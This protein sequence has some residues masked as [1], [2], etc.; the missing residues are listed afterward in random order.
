MELFIQ[1][2]RI[3][4]TIP[5]V[6]YSE[7]SS[8]IKSRR[9]RPGIPSASYSGVYYPERIINDTLYE[10]HTANSIGGSYVASVLQTT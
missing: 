7:Q 10:W 2:V 5:A 3:S 8:L 4:V 1:V 6:R 9:N